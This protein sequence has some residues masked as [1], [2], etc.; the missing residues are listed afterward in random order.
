MSEKE[1]DTAC[2]HFIILLN[3]H[4]GEDHP[5][6]FKDEGLHR[7]I[8]PFIRIR[9]VNWCPFFPVIQTSPRRKGK[10]SEEYYFYL[11]IFGQLMRVSVFLLGNISNKCFSDRPSSW[12]RGTGGRIISKEREREKKMALNL[13]IK[14]SRLQKV[15]ILNLDRMG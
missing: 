5:G 14:H 13:K 10:L 12:I 4:H 2:R 6:L 8:S 7:L 3:T 11:L 9:R 15:Q 1:R